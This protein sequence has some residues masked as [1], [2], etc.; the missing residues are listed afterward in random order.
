MTHSRPKITKAAP[1]FLSIFQFLLTR[2][3]LR[4]DCHVKEGGWW[5]TRGGV[6]AGTTP[7]PDG[8]W[9]PC[10]DIIW[11]GPQVMYTP[12]TSGAVGKQQTNTTSDDRIF[13]KACWVGLGL[14]NLG[15]GPVCWS[16]FTPPSKP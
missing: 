2:R 7:Q 16:I 8:L 5:F 6:Q 11:W 15:C 13:E 9:D 4:G 3:E 12:E 14:F 1:H 10:R